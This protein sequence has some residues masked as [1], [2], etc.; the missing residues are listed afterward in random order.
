MLKAIKN[1]RLTTVLIL[2]SLIPNI[3]LSSC[4]NNEEKI[5]TGETASESAIS[6]IESA[7]QTTA[8]FTSANILDEAD[9]EGLEYLI[10]GREYAKLGAL[11]SYEFVVESEN[12]DIIND[13]VFK[14]NRIVEEQYNVQINSMF[15][16][17]NNL[18]PK[19]INAGDGVYNLIWNHISTMSSLAL[20]GY[21]YDFCKLPHIDIHSPWW[22][23]LATESLTLNGKCYLQMNYI[24]FTGVMLS[25]CL[26]Y[27]Q[28]I[29]DDNDSPDLYSMVLSNEWTFE[30]FAELVKTVSFDTDGNGIYDKMDIFG[31]LSSHGTSG[32]AFSIAMD[33]KTLSVNT[34]GT[35]ELTLVSDKNQSVLEKIVN[36]TSSNSSYMITD[37]ALENDIAK[38]FANDQALFYSGFLTDSYQFFRDM[39]S[40][41]G[42]LPFPKYDDKQ[43][44]YMTTVTGGTGLLGIPQYL[45]DG[46][47]TGFITEALAIESLRYV[48]PAVYDVVIEEKLLRDENSK[49]MFEILMNGLEIDFG[50]T[51]KY[52]AYADLINDLVKAGSTDLA[53]SVAKTEASAKKHYADVLKTFFNEN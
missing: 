11:P 31:L 18:V 1:S 6:D 44:N 53:S 30:Q 37:Y 48:Y 39:N 14:R 29:A 46:D 50:R 24:P 21:L 15:G 40:D 51:F 32:G 2:L 5:N 19:S 36:L 26:Y 43:E 42:L 23:Q 35:L 41:Y 16:D 34:D 22:N 3:L 45:D 4:S 49:A 10:L 20:N 27:N 25:H 17:A 12:G 52:A 38:M 8:E 13:T 9:F 47:F 28:K 33:V 7:A